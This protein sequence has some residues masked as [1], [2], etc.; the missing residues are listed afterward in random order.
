MYWAASEEA[1]EVFGEVEV[2][3]V[4]E[5]FAVVDVFSHAVIDNVTA[6]KRNAARTWSMPL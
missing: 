2:F 4:V 1:V 5:V 6:A 3:G